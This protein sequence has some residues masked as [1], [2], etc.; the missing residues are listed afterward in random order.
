M[1]ID[2]ST[3]TILNGYLFFSVLSYLLQFMAKITKRSLFEI[4]KIENHGTILFIL[5]LYNF[6]DGNEIVKIVKSLN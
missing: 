5:L 2:S 4:K 3:R 1:H 6:T